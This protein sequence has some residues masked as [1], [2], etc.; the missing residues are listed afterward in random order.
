MSCFSLLG[1]GSLHPCRLRAR[2]W[3]WAAGFGSQDDPL[4]PSDTAQELVFDY[5]PSLHCDTTAHLAIGT[6][7]PTA[8]NVVLQIPLAVGL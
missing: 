6:F 7:M 3:M 4:Q 2:L 8:K 1:P 5:L